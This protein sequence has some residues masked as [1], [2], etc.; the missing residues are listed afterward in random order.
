MRYLLILGIIVMLGGCASTGFNAT[1]TNHGERTKYKCKVVDDI[2][3][4]KCV[5]GQTVV[6]QRIG[7]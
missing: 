7:Y 6:V 2:G 1:V 4:V 3:T 5:K